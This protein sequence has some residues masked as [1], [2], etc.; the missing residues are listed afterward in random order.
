M[1]TKTI[2]A[3]VFSQNECHYLLNIT[4]LKRVATSPHPLAMPYIRVSKPSS[5][6]LRVKFNSQVF[7]HVDSIVRFHEEVSPWQE[8]PASLATSFGTPVFMLAEHDHLLLPSSRRWSP[9]YTARRLFLF[10][11]AFLREAATADFDGKD[12]PTLRRRPSRRKARSEWR[13]Y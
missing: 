9:S 2:R 3:C 11:N 5:A 10:H 8:N 1:L 4:T 13:L 6:E 12:S 7:V